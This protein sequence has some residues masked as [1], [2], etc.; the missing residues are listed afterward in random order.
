MCYTLFIIAV[1][2]SP[3]CNMVDNHA[4]VQQ[5]TY[6]FQ[7]YLINSRKKFSVKYIKRA[8]KPCLLTGEKKQLMNWKIDDNTRAYRKIVSGDSIAV[9]LITTCNSQINNFYVQF[10]NL[11]VTEKLRL[12]RFSRLLTMTESLDLLFFSKKLNN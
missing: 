3:C 10:L 9:G 1:S 7:L 8:W 5:K 6:I 2:H 4:G 12:Y 11:C